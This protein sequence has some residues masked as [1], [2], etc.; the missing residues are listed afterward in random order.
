VVLVALLVTTSTLN[1]CAF[2]AV[3]PE[4]IAGLFGG[5]AAGSAGGAAAT[6]MTGV[7]SCAASGALMDECRSAETDGMQ[8]D[9]RQ[10]E[11]TD[12]CV[13]DED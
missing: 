7:V 13:T 9:V 3:I 1:G 2:M 8:A 5:T 4:L 6:G 10:D 11:C 12:V